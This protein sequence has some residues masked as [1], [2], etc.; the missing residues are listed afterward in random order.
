M[1][2]FRRLLAATTLCT[3]PLAA[4][5]GVLAVPEPETLSLIAIG[6]V[7]LII[8]KTRKRK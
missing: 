1:N 7:A 8:A 6:A 4:N 2:V 3:A 5:A